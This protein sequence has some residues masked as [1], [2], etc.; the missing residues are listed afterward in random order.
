MGTTEGDE[1]LR[2]DKEAGRADALHHGVKP[3]TA[4]INFTQKGTSQR[5]VESL[6]G[7]CKRIFFSGLSNKVAQASPIS[8]DSRRER[9]SL[10]LPVL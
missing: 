2:R 3:V 6:F 8:T 4:W 9:N 5:Y 7:D 1:A 10:P